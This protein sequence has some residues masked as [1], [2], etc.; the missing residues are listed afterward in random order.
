MD[1][2]AKLKKSGSCSALVNIHSIQHFF[3]NSTW[4]V[5]KEKPYYRPLTNSQIQ[6]NCK[7]SVL[8]EYKRIKLAETYLEPP[9]KLFEIDNIFLSKPWAKIKVRII[10]YERNKYATYQNLYAPKVVHIRKFVA[11]NAYIRNRGL[12]HLSFHL[13]K[14]E[15]IK[16][17]PNQAESRQ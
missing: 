12:N 8:S 17:N 9:H 6:K 15:K 13:K 5:H 1:F 2:A 14:L 7:W 16:L 11:W 4:D 10:K 3:P